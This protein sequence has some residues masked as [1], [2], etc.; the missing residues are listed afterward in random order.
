MAALET[1]APGCASRSQALLRRRNGVGVAVAQLLTEL[2]AC[3]GPDVVLIIDDAHLVDDD[4]AVAGL[5]AQFLPALAQLAPCRPAV[6][7]A[8][9]APP[10]PA[11][12]PGPTG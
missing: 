12:R 6:S 7:A 10:R 1:A 2:D 4:E 9:A 11:A 3:P 8:T 5:L